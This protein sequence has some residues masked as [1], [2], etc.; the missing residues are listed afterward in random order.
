MRKLPLV[1]VGLVLTCLGLFAEGHAQTT[2]VSRREAEWKSYALPAADFVRR[3]DSSGTVLFRVPANW[4]QE[5]PSTGQ[6]EEKRY[7]FIGP[8]SSLL[9]VSVQKIPDG[10]PLQDYLAAILRQLRNL[11]GSADSLIVRHTELSGL[12]AREILFELPDENGNLSR[13]AGGRM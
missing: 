7:R 12:E 8:H 13:R 5:E 1:T 9:Q 6:Q 2:P 11:P 4:K 10:L 3:V